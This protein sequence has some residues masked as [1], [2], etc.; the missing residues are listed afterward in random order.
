MNP[1]IWSLSVRDY[2]T[3]KMLAFSFA[4]FIVTLMLFMIFLSPLYHVLMDSENSSTIQIETT[5][6]S[7][8]DGTKTTENTH[9]LYDGDSAFLDFIFNNSV[10]SWIVATFSLFLLAMLM[11]VLAMITAI[12]V[13]GFLTPSIMKELHK[14]HYSSLTLESHGN[15]LG[16]MFH[17]LKYVMITFILLIVLFPLY[18]I[19]F[20]NILAINLPF[21]Y[22]FHKFYLMDV[23]GTAMSKEEFKKMMFFHGNQV[24][25]NTFLLYLLS[26]VPFAVL[27]TPVF[28]VLVLGHTVFQN[29]LL[30][31]QELLS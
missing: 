31:Q 2:F 30:Q 22:L 5:K 8:Q 23:G 21:Y 28:N 7:F 19:P 18:F 6:T 26:M 1:N 12:V 15:I 11:F 4:P 10:V 27:F 16:S 17:S 9:I 29:K 24:R 3:K 25:I 13:I 14:R 20:V